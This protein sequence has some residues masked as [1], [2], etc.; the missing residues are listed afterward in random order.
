MYYNT[1]Y[2]K[3]FSQTR[4]TGSWQLLFTTFLDTCIEEGEC[5]RVCVCA[6]VHVYICIVESHLS[7]LTFLME[8]S[9]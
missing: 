8:P 4:A 1:N 3:L 7:K 9:K 5:V 2:S 6:C